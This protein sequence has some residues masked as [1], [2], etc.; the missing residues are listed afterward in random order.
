M[1]AKSQVCESWFYTEVHQGIFINDN[2]KPGFVEIS[3]VMEFIKVG[4][5][6]GVYGRLGVLSSPPNEDNSFQ[7]YEDKCWYETV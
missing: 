2:L 6:L 3:P 4:L 1:Q 5:M 7:G